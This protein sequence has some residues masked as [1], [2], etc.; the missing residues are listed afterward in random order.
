MNRHKKVVQELMRLNSVTIE[1]E[2]IEQEEGELLDASLKT[3]GTAVSWSD[4]AAIQATKATAPA[5]LER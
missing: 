5:K 3:T 2:R 4:F 1:V